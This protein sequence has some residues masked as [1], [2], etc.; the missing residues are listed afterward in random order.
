MAFELFMLLK[1]LCTMPLAIYPLLKLPT[2]FSDEAKLKIL[3][4]VGW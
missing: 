1:S 3:T 4:G 2:N